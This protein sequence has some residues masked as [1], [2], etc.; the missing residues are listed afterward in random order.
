MDGMGTGI[1]W[2]YDIFGSF[3]YTFIQETFEKLSNWNTKETTRKHQPYEIL[4]KDLNMTT[5]NPHI[6]L[7]ND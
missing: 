4:G 7:R 3:L 5:R 1:R 2:I 6:T